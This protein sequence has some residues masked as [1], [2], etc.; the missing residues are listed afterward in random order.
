MWTIPT[1]PMSQR[2][3]PAQGG[4]LSTG[5]RPPHAQ[6]RI[7]Q[8]DNCLVKAT[9]ARAARVSMA[10]PR[11]S[12]NCFT[13]L[14][15]FTLH[16]CKSTLATAHAALHLLTFTAVARSLPALSH[17]KHAMAGMWANPTTQASLS[18]H[19]I[20]DSVATRSSTRRPRPRWLTRATLLLTL[21]VANMGESCKQRLTA[22]GQRLLWGWTRVSYAMS[23]SPIPRVRGGAR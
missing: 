13:H 17:D 21:A 4:R 7:S 5:H 9:E 19:V 12:P 8:L 2:T 14:T 16:P 15:S 1:R 18:A 20:P 22:G 3:V 23:R 10:T 11:A 6:T